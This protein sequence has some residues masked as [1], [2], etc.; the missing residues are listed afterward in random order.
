MLDFVFSGTELLK[1]N[2]NS[3]LKNW[4]IGI[5]GES[6]ISK[7]GK[8]KVVYEDKVFYWF[9]RANSD[10]IPKI[11]ILSEDKKINLEYPLFDREVSVLSVYVLQLLKEYF[12]K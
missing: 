8:R 6:M 7:K 4:K 10:G 2:N 1:Q 5:V 12:V 9:V 11:H 3:S